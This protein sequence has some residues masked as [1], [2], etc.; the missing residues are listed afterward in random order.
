MTGTIINLDDHR[1]ARGL[2]RRTH[3]AMIEEAAA[4]IDRIVGFGCMHERVA[5]IGQ[6][7]MQYERCQDCHRILRQVP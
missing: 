3:I 5:W 4:T 6:P 7:G 1:R 2:I